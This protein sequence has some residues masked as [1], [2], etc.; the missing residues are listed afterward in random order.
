MYVFINED[1]SRRAT[2]KPPPHHSTQQ[3]RCQTE[4]FPS[5]PPYDEDEAPLALALALA[6][7]LTKRF[8]M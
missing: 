4:P 5:F 1:K 3:L 6:V 2:R 8:S 7:C